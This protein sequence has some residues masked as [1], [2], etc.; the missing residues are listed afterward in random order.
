MKIK[1]KILYLIKKAISKIKRN[2]NDYEIS[3]K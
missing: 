1:F 3:L 2:N